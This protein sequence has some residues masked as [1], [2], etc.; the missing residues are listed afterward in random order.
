MY[1]WDPTYV[2][3][4]PAIILAVYAQ[5]KVQSTFRRYSEVQSS[6]GYTGGQAAAALL[7]RQ[8]IT[9]VKIESVQGTLSDHYDPRNKV[10]RLSEQVYAGSSL[11]ALGVAAHEAG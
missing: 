10:L 8:G 11:A 3:V 7:Q 5:F 2:L 6:S 1:F 9:D 4:L